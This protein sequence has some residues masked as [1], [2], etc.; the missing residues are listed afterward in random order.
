MCC[1]IVLQLS[2]HVVK[3]KM[4]AIPVLLWAVLQYSGVLKLCVAA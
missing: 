2:A 1:I 4:L 3:A